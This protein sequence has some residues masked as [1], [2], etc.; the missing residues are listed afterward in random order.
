MKKI[1]CIG[2]ITVAGIFAPAC[3]KTTVAQRIWFLIVLLQ[4]TKKKH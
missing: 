1:V 3:T 2:T 4:T